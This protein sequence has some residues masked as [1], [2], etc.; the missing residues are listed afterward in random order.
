SNGEHQAAEDPFRIGWR[1]V[2]KIGQ[3]GRK[4]WLQVPLTEEDLLHPQEDDHVVNSNKHNID[5]RYCVTAFEFALAPISGAVVLEDCG[6]V[7][8][9][10]GVPVLSRDVTVILGV[11]RIRHWRTFNCRTEGVGPILV[12]ELTSPA[13]R[14]TDLGSKRRRYYRAGVEFYI[15]VDERMRRGQRTLRLIG[16][17]RGRRG[18]LRLAPAFRSRPC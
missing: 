5:R 12:M 16:Y 14:R 10:G 4:E 6:I 18:D 11:G 3:N 1:F 15:I 13:T 9:L 17:Q 8:D 7:W 2:E